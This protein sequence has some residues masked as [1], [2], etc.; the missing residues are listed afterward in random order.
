MPCRISFQLTKKKTLLITE[1]CD[2]MIKGYHD[3]Q[4]R[5]A[6]HFDQQFLSELYDGDLKSAEE[7]FQSSIVQITQEMA[8]AEQLF[9]QND[10]TGLRKIFHRIKPLF[11]YV[12]LLAVQNDVKNF[13]ES[14][15]Q[16][17]ESQSLLPA[18]ENIK[19]IVWDA[20]SK[21]ISEKNRLSDFNNQR[22]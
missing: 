22:A 5:F 17:R 1:N 18:F 14:C 9:R 13:E 2:F 6:P 21:I 11:G 7:V 12:G 10:I 20:S 16:F 3:V 15:I 19:T 4:F 8:D